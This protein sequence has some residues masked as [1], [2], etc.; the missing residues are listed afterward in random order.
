MRTIPYGYKILNGKAEI[1][2][3]E[4]KQLQS[5]YA[6]YLKGLSLT[7][8]AKEA[9]IALN[10]TSVRRLLSKKQYLGDAFYPQIISR[11][12]FSATEGEIHKRAKKLGRLNLKTKVRDLT[13][14]TRFSLKPPQKHCEDA[15]LEAE[16]LYSLIE[17]EDS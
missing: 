2:E 8:A 15:F 5:L 13:V 12:V 10:H 4:A 9:N 17:S 11:E 7:N 6:S 14:P 1:I 16:Y 3:E